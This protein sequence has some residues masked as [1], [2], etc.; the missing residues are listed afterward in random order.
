MADDDAETLIEEYKL[1]TQ[2][3][4]SD[5]TEKATDLPLKSDT[6]QETE[7]KEED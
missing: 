1:K 3:S 2:S 6:N 5:T 7:Q 4:Q